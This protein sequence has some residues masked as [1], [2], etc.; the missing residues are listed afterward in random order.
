MSAGEQAAS[1]TLKENRNRRN[2][3]EGE[4]GIIEEKERDEK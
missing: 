4:N 1:A 2:E 3:T